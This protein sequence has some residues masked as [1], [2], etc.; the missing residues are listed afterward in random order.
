MPDRREIIPLDL[1]DP[2]PWNPKHPIAGEHREGL[3][4]SIDHFGVRDDL[5]VWPNPD[6][7]GRYYV[8]DGN[9]RLDLFKER[10]LDSIECRILDDLDNEDARLFTAAFDR[11]HALYDFRKLGELAA[12]LKLRNEGLKDRLLWL[13]K[14][15]LPSSTFVAE[16]AVSRAEYEPVSTATS[17]AIAPSIPI[18]FSL[19]RDG[20]DEVKESILRSR[21]RLVR[22]TRLR[23]ALA[24]LEEREL[25]DLTVELALRIAAQ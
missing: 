18:M 1:I 8:L 15:N 21:S 4:A 11:N 9:Q 10:G 14:V 17:P 6:Q 20:F 16:S 2:A 24:G 19:T 5:K 25:D 12:N 3:G 23:D 22:E 13:P 7:P